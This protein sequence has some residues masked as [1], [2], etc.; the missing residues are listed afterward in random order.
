MNNKFINYEKS[1]RARWGEPLTEYGFTAISNVF[2]LN[3]FTLGITTE[4]A[5][6]IIH[7]LK[8]KWTV[9][10]PFPSFETI[11]TQMG[12][13]R[14]TIQK[15][16]RSLEGKGLMQRRFRENQPSKIDFSNL[17]KMLINTVRQNPD[18]GPIKKSTPIYSNLD[19]KEDPLKIHIKEKNTPRI[20]HGM[21]SIGNILNER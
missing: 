8:F 4:E 5:L 1:V 16:A 19:T 9:E 11:A 10:D 7:V 13:T 18:R 17:I 21:N 12:K 3:Y 2:L 14:G 20:Y 15:Y 6:F